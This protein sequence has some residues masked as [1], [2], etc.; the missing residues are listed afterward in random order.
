MGARCALSPTPR[1]A[2]TLRSMAPVLMRV[3]A[4]RYRGDLHRAGVG[5]G[6]HGFE[7]ALPEILAA[8]TIDRLIVRRSSDG[9]RLRIHPASP[10]V[11]PAHRELQDA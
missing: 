6:Q 7:A 4:E 8:Q 5:N 3:V 9:A 1:S 10:R 11:M 2:S